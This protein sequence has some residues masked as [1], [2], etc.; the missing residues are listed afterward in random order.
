MGLLNLIYIGT[1][2]TPRILTPSSI[3]YLI[4]TGIYNVYFHPLRHF[5]GPWFSAATSLPRILGRVRGIE[6]YHL[7]WLHDTYGDVVRISPNELSYTTAKAWKDIHGHAAPVGLFLADDGDHGRQRRIF[8][9]AFSDR[10]LKDQEP[11]FR[12]YVELLM[13]NLR[14]QGTATP[15]AK[16]NMVDMYNFTTFDIMADLTFGESL[17]LLAG[18]TYNAWVSGIFAAVKFFGLSTTLRFYFPEI[19]AALPYVLPVLKKKQR[20]HMQYALDRVDRRLAIQTDRPDIWSYVLREKEEGQGARLTVPEMHANATTFM[21]AGTETT[22]TL[23]SG[24]TYLLLRNADKMARLVAE[25]RGA[26][27]S[28]DEMN[29]QNLPQLPYLNA[30]LEEALRVYPPVPGG[31]P[32]LTP[33]G[34]TIIEGEHVPG[35]VTVFVTNWAAYHSS[36]HFALPE[37]YIPER[38]LPDNDDPRFANDDK[39]ILQPFSYGPRN[40]IGKNLAWHEMR[41]ILSYTLWHF[42]LELCGESEDWLDQRVYA[43]WEKKPLMVRLKPVE[44][45]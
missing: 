41:L 42:D 11:L 28:P 2:T 22:A 25:I 30:C 3:A 16:V 5:P 45:E 19:N 18:S 13:A 36:R 23:L 6:P 15:D 9:H 17:Q 31:L 44:R 29:L 24:V 32:R 33:S 39:A 37:E 12:G 34:G 8:S 7:Q 14:S 26:F 43:L 21:I 35:N 10:A 1:A 40:C 20:E 27:A 38:W 4:I